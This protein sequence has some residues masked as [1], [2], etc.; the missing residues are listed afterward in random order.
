MR[1]Y[2]VFCFLKDEWPPRRVGLFVA[3]SEYEARG[4]AANVMSEEG[5]QFAGLV[6]DGPLVRVIDMTPNMIAAKHIEVKAVADNARPEAVVR[7][8]A[9]DAIG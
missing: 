9:S 7:T 5:L 6:W 3:R 2:E 8:G 4:E 1:I